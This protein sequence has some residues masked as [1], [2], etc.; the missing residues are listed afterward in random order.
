[1]QADRGAVI[2]GDSPG[3]GHSLADSYQVPTDEEMTP[4][5]RNGSLFYDSGIGTSLG[6]ASSSSVHLSK[7][8]PKRPLS[9]DTLL[10]DPRRRSSY[11][12]CCGSTR[13]YNLQE[14]GKADSRDPTRFHGDT[15]GGTAICS[16][17]HAVL[18][19]AS[20]SE[21]SS[22]N[23]LRREEYRIGW[24]SALKVEFRAAL[25]MLDQRHQPILGHSSDDNLYVQGRVGIHNVVLTCLP[26]GRY[27]TNFAAM[28]AT[29]MMN[30]YPNIQIGFMVGIGGGLPSPQNDIRLGDVIVSRPEREHGGVVQYDMGKYTVDGFQRTGFLN[31]PP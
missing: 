5:V 16:Q 11:L 13:P 26:E 31:A 28:V 23:S 30:T 7:D 17:I 29:R 12:P 27:G 14:T 20:F 24:I 10:S 8:T 25:Q 3:P 19:P 6:S 9:P 21:I 18:P 2:F 1:M 15:T 4:C 22:R